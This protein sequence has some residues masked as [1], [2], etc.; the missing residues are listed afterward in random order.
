MINILRKINYYFSSF[1]LSLH[2]QKGV[3]LFL[4]HK[5]FESKKDMEQGTG[6]PMEKLLVEDFRLFV[7]Y[8]LNQGYTFVSDR[9]LIEPLN[10]GKY[11][12]MSFDDGY[13]SSTLIKDVLEEYKI[14]CSFYVCPYY[15]SS[16]EGFWFDIFYR[17]RTKMG[18]NLDKM[19]EEAKYIMNL[20]PEESRAYI[21]KTFGVKA[22]ENVCPL[23]RVMTEKE[24]IELAK[25]P[26]VYIGNHTY[27]HANLSVLD[28]ENT[29]KEIEKAQSWLLNIVPNY[30]SNTISFPYGLY[31][32]KITIEVLKEMPF[33]LAI[34]QK[35]YKNYFPFDNLY[36][37]NK[38]LLLNR[39]SKRPYE[40]YRQSLRRVRFDFY[41]ED[42]GK[43]LLGR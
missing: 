21:V 29:L 1:L 30:D 34:R 16:Q 8:F 18:T 40:S 36:Q 41:F 23:H 42:W 38:F 31:D 32:E 10:L 2:E 33:K 17:E 12:H 43:A 27:S 6:D 15:I 25:C 5:L 11:I 35:K 9:Q 20:I 28:F 3:I 24:L 7:D 26:Y 14:E 13:F 22:I 4:F 37:E 39:T 19:G